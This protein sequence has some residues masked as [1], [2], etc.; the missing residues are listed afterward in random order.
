MKGAD[1]F[2]MIVGSV[3]ISIA[4]NIVRSTIIYLY[5][6][7]RLIGRL[8]ISLMGAVLTQFLTMCVY[9]I[10]FIDLTWGAMG[11]ALIMA[12]LFPNVRKKNNS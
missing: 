7:Y 12:C 8:F 9:E 11:I 1:V 5:Q 10:E 6:T 4:V 3:V 2:S